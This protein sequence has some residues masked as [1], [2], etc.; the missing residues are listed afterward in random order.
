[1]ARLRFRFFPAA[2]EQLALAEKTYGEGQTDIQTVL[3]SREQ[4]LRLETSRIAAVEAFH[5]AR[6]NY[7]SQLGY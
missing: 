3:R 1:M 7:E 5:K 6:A 4:K 2:A